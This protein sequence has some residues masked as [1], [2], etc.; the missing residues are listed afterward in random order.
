V[1]DIIESAYR[2]AETG[3]RQELR[4]HLPLPALRF[5]KSTR[6]AT[7]RKSSRTRSATAWPIAA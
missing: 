4:T 5:G 3:M 1:I 6:G 7:Q 2:A